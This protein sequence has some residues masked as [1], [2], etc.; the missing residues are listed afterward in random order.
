MHMPAAVTIDYKI[1]IASYKANT[2][3]FV[4]SYRLA[5]QAGMTR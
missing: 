1:E 2:D 3:V 4:A 5:M